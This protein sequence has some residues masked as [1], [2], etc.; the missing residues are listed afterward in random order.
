MFKSGI[1]DSWVLVAVERCSLCNMVMWVES[2][3]LIG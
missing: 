3:E 2:G 1:V